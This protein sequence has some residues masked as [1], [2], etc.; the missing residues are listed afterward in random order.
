MSP[1][2]QVKY[3]CDYDYDNQTF[4]L[5]EGETLFLISKSNQDWWLCLRL[6]E[7][8]TFFVPATYVKEIE[9]ASSNRR[10]QPPPRPPPPPPPAPVS[11]AST[12]RM[13][14]DDVAA[15]SSPKPQVKKRQQHLI[16]SNSSSITS[17]AAA[18]STTT[19]AQA[20]AASSGSITSRANFESVQSVYENLA[21]SG[22]GP[23][24]LTNHNNNDQDDYGGLNPDAIIS[25]LDDR[26]NREEESFVN[27][28]E[29]VANVSIC[30]GGGVLNTSVFG[31]VESSVSKS[32]LPSGSIDAEYVCFI[33]F[34]LFLFKSY[35]LIIFKL[36][37]NSKMIHTSIRIFQCPIERNR[38]RRARPSRERRRHR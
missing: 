6:A 2:V 36:T 13:S 16:S 33:R 3:N 14:A 18:K 1:L 26:L 15:V 4:H 34:I 20:V 23:S 37:F 8:L 21:D 17:T 10:L 29:N 38:H 5:V 27:R 19:P 12:S 30:G 31:V 35:F 32:V 25:D 9:C 7:K 24:R 28:A 11:R 22:S